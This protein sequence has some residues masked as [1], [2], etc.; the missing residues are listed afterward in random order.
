LPI[1]L[2]MN[3]KVPTR[4]N[5]TLF[6]LTKEGGTRLSIASFWR[7]WRFSAKIGKKFSSM[8]KLE[9]AHRLDHM[10]K[11]FLW[12]LSERKLIYWN[13]W[14]VSISTICTT[15]PQSCLNSRMK[16]IIKEPVALHGTQRVKDT[17]HKV[18]LIQP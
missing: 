18:K 9:L 3:I 15:Y 6:C 13:F 10:H 2:S 7:L 12:S 11:S 14:K 1:F 4:K 5:K 16:T 17:I 8:S